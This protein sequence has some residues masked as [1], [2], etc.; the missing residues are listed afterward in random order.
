LPKD[1]VT[2]SSFFIQIFLVAVIIIHY[3]IIKERL[4][5]RKINYPIKKK[6]EKK[7]AISGGEVGHLAAFFDHLFY[8]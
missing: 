8:Y 7:G 1:L 4:K 5:S 2:I 6:K 3:F